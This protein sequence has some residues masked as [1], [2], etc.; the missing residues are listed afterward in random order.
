MI[1]KIRSLWQSLFGDVDRRVRLGRTL[2]LL[3][4]V[5][6]FVI[7]GFAWNGAAGQNIVERQFPYVLSGGFMGLALVITG[8][9]LIFLATL[10]AERAV[11]TDRFDQMLTLLSRNLGRLQVTS[12][13]AGGSQEQV[14]ATSEA[15]HRADCAVLKGKSGLS[16]I[17]VEQAAA[18]G[19]QP[20]RTCEPPRPT[21]A[22]VEEQTVTTS[23]TPNQ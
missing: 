9:T 13:G 2:G 20:C 17:S 4:V 5:A 18:E 22:P 14:V 8:S 19:L 6:G 12:N 21:R 1:K 10:R 16:T 23:G 3:F 7:L 11:L 15:Y